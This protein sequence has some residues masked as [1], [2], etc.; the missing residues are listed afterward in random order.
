MSRLFEII[1]ELGS[2]QFGY[3]F[4]AK[5]KRKTVP[6]YV[7]LKIEK[8]NNDLAM[9]QYE[10]KIIHYLNEQ[11]CYRVP[12]VFWYGMF[13]G[14]P[15]MA[16]TH[17]SISLEDYIYKSGFPTQH[18]ECEK[19]FIEMVQILKSIHQANVIH[20]DIKPANFMMKN[21]RIYLVDFGLSKIYVDEE[22]EIYPDKFVVEAFL[23]TPKYISVFIHEG[24]SPSLRD[25]MISCLYVYLF[26]KTKQLPWDVLP[27][28]STENDIFPENHI[29]EFYNQERMDKKNQLKQKVQD[30]HLGKALKLME[31]TGF[32]K[33][34]NYN[35]LTDLFITFV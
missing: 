5:R 7:A 27:R 14:N 17:Y 6:S 22:N 20:C 34:P 15:A 8:K 1:D 25:D 31:N 16:M 18:N 13:E 24:H 2:G 11:Q 33:T 4:L 19:I 32:G 29:Q 9:I 10:S 28:K 21:E 35:K 30:T 12:S 26:S 23:G 3:V